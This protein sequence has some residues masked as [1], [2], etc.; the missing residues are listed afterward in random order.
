MASGRAEN[1]LGEGGGG[2]GGKGA[3]PYMSRV[4]GELLPEK[5]KTLIVGDGDF[6]YSASLCKLYDFSLMVSTS[7]DTEVQLKGK[8]GDEYTVE[9]VSFL[10]SNG[11]QV[12]HGVDATDLGT[13]LPL[14]QSSTKGDPLSFDVIIFNFPH[15]GGKSNIKKSRL[16]LQNFFSSSDPF[17]AAGGKVVVTLAKGQGGTAFDIVKREKQNT[18][19]IVEAGAASGFILAECFPWIPME[20]YKS[21]GYRSTKRSFITR[22]GMTHIFVK[23]N[24]GY[25]S[26]DPPTW[27]HDL[28][29][30]V[31]DEEKYDENTLLNGVYSIAGEENI[32]S[33]E[34]IDSFRITPRDPAVGDSKKLT[35]CYK[36]LYRNKVNRALPKCG[37]LALQT[38]V[39]EGLN[40]ATAGMV[41]VR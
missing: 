33:F 16:L 24:L 41:I 21:S 34:L 25:E 5:C 15:Q 7:F 17:L 11:V 9:V 19:K 13:T 1:A 14:L 20:G 28:S 40:E 10:T 18:W 23:D 35:H 26:L 38:K 36:L 2:G 6:S 4:F 30:W 3:T 22:D 31:V 8:Y 37:A 39:R 29:L 27:R 12:F 32:L